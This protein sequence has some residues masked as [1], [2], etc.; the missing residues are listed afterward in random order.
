MGEPCGE[1]LGGGNADP[2]QRIFG[3]C[4]AFLSSG[5]IKQPGSAWNRVP[6]LT[7]GS[8]A[9]DDPAGFAGESRSG[10]TRGKPVRCCRGLLA[11]GAE[12][13]ATFSLPRLLLA[14]LNGDM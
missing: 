14:S 6:G 3:G 5:K 10:E 8:G 7:L 13:F 1:G 4:P 9:G 2:I 12:N 11:F